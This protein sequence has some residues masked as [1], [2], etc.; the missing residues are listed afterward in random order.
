MIFF[1]NIFFTS[2]ILISFWPI[3]QPS[4]FNFFER[5]GSSF[6]REQFSR[7][8]KSIA[9]TKK[10]IPTQYWKNPSSRK[11]P[12]AVGTSIAKIGHL[13]YFCPIFVLYFRICPIFVLFMSHFFWAEYNFLWAKQNHIGGVANNSLDHRNRSRHPK[14][15]SWINTGKIRQA[16]RLPQPSVHV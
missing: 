5:Y 16:G 7:P 9:P 3:W 4:A 14:N 13:S 10:P 11:A 8:P 2:K 12:S 15:L 1:F 6:S